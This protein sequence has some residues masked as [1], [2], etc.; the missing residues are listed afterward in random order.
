MVSLT[1]YLHSETYRTF[2]HGI[3]ARTHVNITRGIHSQN[4]L[5]FLTKK[6]RPCRMHQ[7]ELG[8]SDTES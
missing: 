4:M 8:R 6:T 2:A 7:N 5:K 3:N 1:V